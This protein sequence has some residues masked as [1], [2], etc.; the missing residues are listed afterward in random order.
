MQKLGDDY[1]NGKI[2]L[3]EYIKKITVL[4]KEMTDNMP[5]VGI[6]VNAGYESKIV[7]TGSNPTEPVTFDTNDNRWWEK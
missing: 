7:G 4:Q 5:Q 3:E 1:Q 6:T 2:S